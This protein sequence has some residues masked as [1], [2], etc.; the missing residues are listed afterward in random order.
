MVAIICLYGC[1]S[2]KRLHVDVDAR[3]DVMY[4]HH[5]STSLSEVLTNI[6]KTD[7]VITEE[8]SQDIKV[9][10]TITTED[11]DTTG[12]V[13]RRQVA[14]VEIE[15]A[16][17]SSR[18][19]VSVIVD[20]TLSETTVSIVT[21]DTMAMVT[22][23]AGEISEESVR[24]PSYGSMLAVTLAIMALVYIMKRLFLF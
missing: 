17:E 7:G 23:I 9:V 18:R 2:K 10:A 14:S 21:R 4:E 3:S 19:D 20:S 12:R 24:M 11:L 16:H 6:V 5:N 13:I 22:E 15:S 1:G 8:S